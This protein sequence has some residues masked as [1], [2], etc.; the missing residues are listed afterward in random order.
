MAWTVS[1]WILML[2]SFWYAGRPIGFGIG[3]VL[4]TIWRY[5]AASLLAG[6]A[7]AWLAWNFHPF[8]TGEGIGDALARGTTVSLLFSALYLVAVVALFRSFE[9]VQQL[10]KLLPDM[11]PSRRSPKP[12]PVGVATTGLP[13]GAALQMA[14]E[15]A[16]KSCGR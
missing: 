5:V 11:L 9:P 6:C 13:A 16:S 4:E 14:G 2:P 1:F 12:A 8:G 15:E 3:P 7:S 10:V